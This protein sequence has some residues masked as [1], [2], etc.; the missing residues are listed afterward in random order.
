VM[1][2]IEL[3]RFNYFAASRFVPIAAALV[4]ILFS[5]HRRPV[6]RMPYYAGGAS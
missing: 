2:L 5:A 3:L 6:W 1:F 4:L